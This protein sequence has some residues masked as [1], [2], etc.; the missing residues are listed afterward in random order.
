M[1][2]KSVEVYVPAIPQEHYRTV[3]IM[4]RY[5][6]LVFIKPGGNIFVRMGVDIRVDPERH[7]SPDSQSSRQGV[8]YLEFLK[9]F[10][11]ECKNI[12]LQR[13][14][15][16]L[17]CLPRSGKDCLLRRETAPYGTKDLVP[18]YAIS[19]YPLGAYCLKNPFIGICLDG[20]VDFDSVSCGRFRQ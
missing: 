13:M 7:L 14:D 20:V 3:E 2:M 8:Q 5:A 19:S 10:T 15:D 17:I 11:V 16:F 12:S 6:E 4:G 18:A 9:G 1:E